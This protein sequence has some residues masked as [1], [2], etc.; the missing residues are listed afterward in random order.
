L[1]EKVNSK[2][3]KYAFIDA[4]RGLAILSVVFFHTAVVVAPGSNLLWMVKEQGARGVQLFYIASALTIFLSMR[5][6]ANEKSRTRNFF[7]RRFFRIAP[8]FYLAIIAYLLGYGFGPRAGAPYGIDGWHI[9]WTVLFLNGWHPEMINSVIPVGWS[10]AVEMTFYLLAPLLFAR[11]KKMH[12]TLLFVLVTL[13]LMK[14]LQEI[15]FPPLAAIYPDQNFFVR[16]YFYLWFFAQLPVFVLGILVYQI[17]LKSTENPDRSLGTALLILSIFLFISFLNVSTYANLLP[18]HILYAIAFG[19]F[20]LALA[21]NPVRLFV[22]PITVWIGKLSYSVYLIHFGIAVLL[23]NWIGD[24]ISAGDLN[25]FLIFLLLTGIT[26]PISW[27]TYTFVEE[28]G[29]RLG[30]RIIQL[31]DRK[32]AYS[33]DAGTN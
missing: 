25:Y 26:L 4:L 7:I 13:V 19:I 5:G 10:I 28:P 17:F 2:I 9:L 33:I 31:L 3:K 1:P 32:R 23:L 27:L 6:R 20:A 14:L 22:N 24:N 15:L 11:L 18:V 16:L 29:V 12:Q 8:L 21:H 30:K